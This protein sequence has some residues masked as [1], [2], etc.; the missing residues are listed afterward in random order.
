MNAIARTAADPAL[1][2]H[3]IAAAGGRLMLAAIFLLSG[4]A[5]LADPAGTIGYIQSVG[6]PLPQLGLA[7]AIAVEIIGAAMLVAGYRTRLAAGGLALFTVTTA[8]AFHFDLGDQN[9]FIHFF[10]NV[11][12]AGGLVQVMALGS[13]RLAIEGRG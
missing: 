5:K 12:I 13:G 11:A 1:S 8:L 4:L 9:Q 10:K 3:D 6:L 7:A 2:N